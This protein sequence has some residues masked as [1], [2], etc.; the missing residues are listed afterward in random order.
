MDHMQKT[1]H[2]QGILVS[3]Q[4]PWDEQERFLED[5]FRREVRRI[6]DAGFRQMYVFGTAGEGHAVDTAR[7]RAIVDVFAEET[8]PRP[9]VLPQVGTIGLS[10]ATGLERLQ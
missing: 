5:A 3:C 4:V 1:R 7:F 9:G 6:I 10:P 2:P 8:L